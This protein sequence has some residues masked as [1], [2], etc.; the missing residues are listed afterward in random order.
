MPAP[1]PL[2]KDL[3]ETQ[4]R[5][6]SAAP[7]TNVLVLAGAGSGKTRVLAHRVAWLV[8]QGVPPWGILAVTFTNKAAREMRERIER[9]IQQPAG[10]LW[11][12]TFHGLAHRLLRLHWA[13]AGLPVSFQI[14]DSDDQFRLVRRILKDLSLDETRWPP[15]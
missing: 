10:G 8:D 4:C 12:G 1:H 2:L 11:I 13:E 3:N 9:L 6:V 14:I 5:A 15:R 7:N